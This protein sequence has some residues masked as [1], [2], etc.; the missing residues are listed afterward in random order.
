MCM[1]QLQT[2]EDPLSN[3]I[4]RLSIHNCRKSYTDK[5]VSLI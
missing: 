2:V 4:Y 5:K 1:L 3:I